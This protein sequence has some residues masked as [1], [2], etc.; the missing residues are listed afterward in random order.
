MRAA[1]LVFE[2]HGPN[3]IEYKKLMRNKLHSHSKLLI[4]KDIFDHTLT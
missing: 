4:K 1:K 2:A 3:S